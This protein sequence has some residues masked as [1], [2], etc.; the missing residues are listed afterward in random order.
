MKMTDV[1]LAELDW[2]AGMTRRVLERIPAGQAAW[3]PH[4]KSMPLGCLASLVAKLPSWIA[5]MIQL[6]EYDLVPSVRPKYHPQPLGTS[7]ELVQ[8]LNVSV[9][10]A[11]ESLRD[12]TDEHLLAPL[13]LLVGGRVKAELPRHQLICNTV[14]SHLAHH[15]GQLTVYLRLAQVSVPAIYGPSADEATYSYQFFM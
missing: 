1:F 11:Y 5:M 13:R 14:F 10:E 15:R 6:K 8:L 7:R 3:Q 12:T 2:E 4:S 9:A